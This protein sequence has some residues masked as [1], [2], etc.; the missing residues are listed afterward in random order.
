MPYTL[1][2]WF[3]ILGP[4]VL[5]VLLAGCAAPSESFSFVVAADMRYYTPPDYAG[6]EYFTG[7]CKSIRKVGPGAFL[8]S[9]GD[10]DPPDRVRAVIDEVLGHDYTWYPVVGNHEGDQ[11]EYMAYLRAYN[12]GGRSL[13]G[14]VR[15][16]PPGA[17]ETCYAFN[18]GQAH[19][20]VINEYYDGVSDM[21]TDG[22][23]TDGTY[24]WLARDLA[25]NDK[26]VTF[27]FGHEPTVVVPDMDNGRVRHRGD[28]L[29]QYEAHNHRFWSLLRKHN[30]LAY[31]CGHSHN[32]SVAKIN[33]VWQVDCGHARGLGDRGAMSSFVKVLVEGAVVRCEVY[34]SEG[35]GNAYRLVFAERLR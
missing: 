18:H 4:T 3:V 24:A 30:V 32:C 19:F 7:A 20:V 5:A 35:P 23:V 22:D 11:A 28:S 16:G 34:R 21:G 27:V 12:R 13:P 31:F 8:V 9:P 2:R 33:G 26:P 15:A 29:D 1:D 17:V 10:G 6:P 25:E 14:V